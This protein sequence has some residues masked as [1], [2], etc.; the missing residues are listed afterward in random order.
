[1]RRVSIGGG[2]VKG[3]LFLG[4]EN[5]ASSALGIV[6]LVLFVRLV[7]SAGFGAWSV[8][9][10]VASVSGIPGSG[11]H[12]VLERFLPEYLEGSDDASAR[13]LTNGVL[14][15]KLVLAAAAAAT[16]A[17]LAPSSPHTSTVQRWRR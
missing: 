13:R 7:G 11:L 16:L 9:Y 12:L 6:F 3:A 10:A 17:L 14:A 8:A 2:I 4:M 1:M 5:L 15:A